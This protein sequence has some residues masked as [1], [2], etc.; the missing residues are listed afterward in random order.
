[1]S[2]TFKTMNPVMLLIVGVALVMGLQLCSSSAMAQKPAAALEYSRLPSP[3]NYNLYRHLAGNGTICYVVTD[4][5]VI[6]H[7]SAMSISC[8]KD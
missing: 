2:T 4:T 3:S 6:S 5:R 7:A 1:M 8:T